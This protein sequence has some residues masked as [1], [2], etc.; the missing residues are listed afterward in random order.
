MAESRSL[1]T[2][3]SIAVAVICAGWAVYATKHV[4]RSGAFSSAGSPAAASQQGPGAGTSR[5]GGAGAPTPVVTAGAK[6]EALSRELRA[7]GTARANEAVEVT[8]KLSNIVTAVRFADGQKV[9]RGQVLVQLDSA[10]ARADLSVAN[11]ALTESDSQ[12]KRA[13]ELLA[14]QLVSKSQFEQL[15]ATRNANAARVDAARAKLE[16]TVIRAPFNGRVGL[17]RVS[18]GSLINP[19]TVITTLD[20][21]GS[22]K[23]DFSVPETSLGLLRDNLP[24]A[25]QSSAYPDKRFIGKVESIDSRIDPTTRS[26]T[27]RGVVPNPDGLL[28]P[29]MFLTIELTRD[30]RQALVIPEEALVPEQDKQFVYVVQ[31][32]KSLRR[33]VRIGQRRPGSVEIVAGLKA[34]ERV[35]VEGTVKV[36]DGGAVRD[37]ANDM[38]AGPAQAADSGP[39][40]ASPGPGPMNPSTVAQ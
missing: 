38:P 32:G 22:M 31:N 30:Q 13:Q 17:R 37:Q 35:V 36:R 29:G 26:V 9:S 4:D 11:A 25:A 15:E 24:L 12:F 39:V 34:G 1:V 6:T 23:V 8:S 3:V 27:V 2:T 21:L 19:G 10:Q 16:D 5:A 14:T 7:L 20:D 28:K 40:P 33:E 18:L